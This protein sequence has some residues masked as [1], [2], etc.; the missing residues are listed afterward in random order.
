MEQEMIEAG[1]SQDKR[2]DLISGMSSLSLEERKIIMSPQEKEISKKGDHG[3]A[4]F[5]V[6]RKKNKA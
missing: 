2:D 5:L 3:Q 4:E 1:G 6:S